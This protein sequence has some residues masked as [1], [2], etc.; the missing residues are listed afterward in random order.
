MRS[1]PRGDPREALGLVPVLLAAHPPLAALAAR[2]RE[3]SDD[4][5]ASGFIAGRALWTDALTGDRDAALRGPSAERLRRLGEIVD[6][7]GRPWWDAAAAR[8]GDTAGAGKAT[9]GAGEA[10]A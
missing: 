4:G 10:S 7:H 9:A 6:A 8:A 1:G 2:A 5:G 3:A